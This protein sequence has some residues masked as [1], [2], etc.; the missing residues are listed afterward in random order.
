M[1]FFHFPTVI[2]YMPFV[3]NR[4]SPEELREH[5]FQLD[6]GFQEGGGWHW[7]SVCT[8]YSIFVFLFSWQKSS[9]RS[10]RFL[11]YSQSVRTKI[12]LGKFRLRIFTTNLHYLDSSLRTRNFI[13]ILDRNYKF[14]G[15][16]TNALSLSAPL[17]NKL[18]QGQKHFSESVFI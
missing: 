16:G 5:I 11:S 17:G 2:S 8:L 18:F 6:L 3:Y 4:Q 10:S 9:P 7:K 1:L 14:S 13:S 15:T 12:F